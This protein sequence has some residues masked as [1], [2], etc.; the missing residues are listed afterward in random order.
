MHLNVQRE[1]VSGVIS[2]IFS[3]I[4]S[5]FLSLNILVLST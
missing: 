3:Y 1:M 5:L 4:A 2:V